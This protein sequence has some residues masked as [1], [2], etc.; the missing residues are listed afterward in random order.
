M[1]CRFYGDMDIPNGRTLHD[2]QHQEAERFLPRNIRTLR[3]RLQ[4]GMNF[5]EFSNSTF[6]AFY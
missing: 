2:T 4:E 1:Y 6:S 3:S 5:G